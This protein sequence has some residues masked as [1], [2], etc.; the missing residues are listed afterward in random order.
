M[1]Y[2]SMWDHSRLASLEKTHEGKEKKMNGSKEC[3]AAA[4]GILDISSSLMG[5]ASI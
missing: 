5:L 1:E 4:F 2:S 3:L